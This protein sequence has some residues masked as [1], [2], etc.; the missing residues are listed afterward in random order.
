MRRFCTSGPVDKKTCYY[1]ERPDIMEEALDH[2]ENWRYFTVS[3]PRQTGKTTLLNDIVEKTKDKYLPIFISFESYVSKSEDDFLETFVI[4]ILDDI[5][6]RYNKKIKLEIPKKLDKIREMLKELYE[7]IGK[8]IILMIDEFEKLDENIM[9]EF[10]HVIRSVYHKKQIYKLRSVILISVGYLSGILEDNASP[11]NIAEHLEV[12]YFTKEQVY[13]LL[14]QHE[15]ETGQIFDEKVKELIWHNAAGQPGLTNGLAY[16]LV[17][18]KAKGEKIITVKHFEKTL[19]DYIRKYIDKN[20]ENIISKAKKEKEL[21]MKIL[22]EPESIEF[23][24]SDDRIKFLYLNGVIDDCDGKCCVKVPLY[25][26]KLYNHFK[27]Q[28]N[29]E[30]N[31]MATIK[32]TIKPYLKENGSLDLNKLMKRYIR[33]IKERGAV[34]FKGRNYYEGVYQYNLDQFLGLYVEAADGKVYPETQVGGGRIDL[35]INMR[36]KEYLIEIKANITGNDYEKSKKQI[37]EYI[38]RKGLKEGWLIIYSNTIKDFEYILEE[39]NGIKLHIWFIKT[40]FE[41]PSK[42]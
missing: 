41:N 30:K 9:N 14:N 18:K 10:L 33:Y 25:Y 21:M 28:I 37:K 34:M 16:D 35:L 39:E 7:K 20:M 1:V 19:Y 31:Y 5:E 42:I 26:K 4:D 29:G 36:N 32:D 22:F 8:E 12:P 24:I 17:M 27:P 6:Y 40:N 2:I 23:D 11:F 13:D 38:K 15:K 3:A